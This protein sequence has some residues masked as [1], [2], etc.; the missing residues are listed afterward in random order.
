MGAPP[1]AS[2]KIIV[3]VPAYNEA[4]RIGDTLRA[5]QEVRGKLDPRAATLL[6]YV[7]DDGSTDETRRRSEEA[8]ADRVLR[9]RVNM[10]LGAA[11][12]TGLAAARADGADI[13]IKFD[14]DLQHDPGDIPELV[15]PILEDEAD[16][17]YGNRFERIEYRMP[18][19]RRLGNLF[20]TA[21]MRWLTRWPLKDSQ[22]GIFAVNRAY[23]EVFHLPGDY[24]YTQQILI[25]AYHKG[26]RFAHTPVAFRK[27]LTG[28]SFIGAKYPF[29]VLSQII[30]V[31]ASV[32]PMRIFA[33]V[34]L[35]CILLAT[36]IFG[37][38]FATWLF[39]TAA[40][41]VLHVNA[42]LGLSLFGIQTLFFGIIA[43]LIIQSRRQ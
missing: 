22:P 43:E 3:V 21:L 30:M 38:E 15:R 13:V 31:I 20:F 12:R 4:E 5:L 1:A 33:P 16:V 37:V 40:K 23:L 9:H 19:V 17:V 42:V 11:V 39:G 36:V 41:P 28:K 29:K 27:R 7:V 14:A 10:G 25:D 32:N 35:L 2:R 6:L 18:V 34:G 24:N 8:G 26:M